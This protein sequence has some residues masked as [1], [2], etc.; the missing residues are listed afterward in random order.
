[1]WTSILAKHFTIVFSFKNT[2]MT[3]LD[4]LYVLPKNLMLFNEWILKSL[5]YLCTAS[6]SLLNK[7]SFLDEQHITDKQQGHLVI[8]YNGKLCV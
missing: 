4:Y 5:N 7:R 3:L 2:F 8:T 1:M 6:L